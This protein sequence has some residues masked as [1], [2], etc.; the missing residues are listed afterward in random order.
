MSKAGGVGIYV[1]NSIIHTLRKDLNFTSKNSELFWFELSMEVHNE[2]NLVGLIY[3]Y[4][5]NST[6]DFTKQFSEFLLTNNIL[7]NI[8]ICIFGEVNTNLLKKDKDT[9]IKN[10]LN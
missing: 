7:K 6:G 4:P 5:G 9:S 8:D 1:K 10:C 3:R 2:E